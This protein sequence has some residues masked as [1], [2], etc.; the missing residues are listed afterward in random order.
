MGLKH[1]KTEWITYAT[2]GYTYDVAQ[3]QRSAGGGPLHQIRY[4]DGWQTRIVQSNGKHSA[5]GP[6]E[7]VD[8][9][10][11]KAYFDTAVQE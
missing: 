3:D 2:Y 6:I 4:A 9:A 11:G 8:D 7:A 10:T 5:N 1:D